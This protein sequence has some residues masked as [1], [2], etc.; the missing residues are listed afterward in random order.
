[1]KISI[2]ED[3]VLWRI[4]DNIGLWGSKLLLT[5]AECIGIVYDL[6]Q[7]LGLTKQFAFKKRGCTVDQKVVNLL[8]R[9]LSHYTKNFCDGFFSVEWESINVQ[10]EW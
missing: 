2:M 10:K 4:M 8:S 9:I 7:L 5:V 6:K 1:M 3:Y